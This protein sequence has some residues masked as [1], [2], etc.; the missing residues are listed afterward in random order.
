MSSDI[1]EDR[2]E[3]ERHIEE[4]RAELA[5]TVEALA[6]KADV[7]ARAKDRASELKA[8]VQ[9]QARDRAGQFGQTAGQLRVSAQQAAQQA[10]EDPR[11]K[12]FGAA[13]VGALVAVGLLVWLVR[14]RRT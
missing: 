4:T 14:R 12:T 9:Q 10:Q 8:T 2:D 5:D 11:A 3:L 7:K 1:P 13:G 6:Y